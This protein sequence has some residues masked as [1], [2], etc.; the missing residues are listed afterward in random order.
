[1]CEA[2]PR[3]AVQAQQQEKHRIQRGSR[4]ALDACLHCILAPVTATYAACMRPLWGHVDGGVVGMTDEL[5]L[6]PFQASVALSGRYPPR[7]HLSLFRSVLCS[8]CCVSFGGV[9]LSEPHSVSCKSCADSSPGVR[10]C[11][12]DHPACI[13]RGRP[14]AAMCS[15]LRGACAAATA[16]A[17]PTANPAMRSLC[18]A[19]VRLAQNLSNRLCLVV[20]N[21]EQACYMVVPRNNTFAAGCC[22]ARCSSL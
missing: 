4:P 6:S 12:C 8:P 15:K 22:A 9:G 14:T 2:A 19:G 21:A 11:F 13:M 5:V 16:A 10:L 7:G 18:V 17:Q 20:N 3:N 1:M